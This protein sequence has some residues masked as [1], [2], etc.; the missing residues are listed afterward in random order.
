MEI[1]RD[2]PIDFK[3]TPSESRQCT[4]WAARRMETSLIGM[5]ISQGSFPDI[6]SLRYYTGPLKSLGIS[7][8]DTTVQRRE[9]IVDQQR[10]KNEN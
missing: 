6:R 1:A 4:S 3:T 2:I 8:H 7:I 5:G 9:I 10:S